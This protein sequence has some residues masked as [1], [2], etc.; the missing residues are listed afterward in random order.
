[1]QQALRSLGVDAEAIGRRRPES[2]GERFVRPLH[3]LISDV[4]GLRVIEANRFW[5]QLRANPN[6]WNVPAI[7]DALPAERRPAFDRLMQRWDEAT[8]PTGE[9][10]YRHLSEREHG[11]VNRFAPWERPSIGPAG[12]SAAL[13]EH[14]VHGLRFLDANSRNVSTSGVDNMRDIL[15]NYRDQLARAPDDPRL[16]GLIQQAERDLSDAQREVE[17]MRNRNLVVWN[18]RIIDVMRRYGIAGLLGAGTVGAATQGAPDNPYL[19]GN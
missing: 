1:M 11:E 19:Q 4:P 7:R 10:I 14:G 12:A 6:S 18:D 2:I 16:P 8:Q 5:D 3:G 13:G 15:H 17:S 9:D